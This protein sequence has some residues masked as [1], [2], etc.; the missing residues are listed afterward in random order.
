MPTNLRQ[1]FDWKRYPEAEQFL[2]D[3]IV[4]FL[5]LNSQTS[6]LAYSIREK[7]SSPFFH[8]LDHLVLPDSK[9]TLATL[10]E[11]GFS[12]DPLAETSPGR[13]VY[14]HPGAVFP[15]VILEEGADPKKPIL[16]AA[17]K[18]ESV[19]DFT[20]HHCIRNTIEGAPISRFRKVLIYEENNTRLWAVERRAYQGY[21]TE[22]PPF[23]YYSNYLKAQELWRIRPRFFADDVQGILKTE[24]LVE[25]MISLVGKGLAGH[26]IFEGERNYWLKRNRTAQI[27]KWRQD[28]LGLGWTNHDHHT[29]RCSRRHLHDLVRILEKLGF[30]CRE[31]FYAG[32]EAGWGAQILEHPVLD[33]SIFADLDLAPEETQEDFAHHPL[34]MRK[35]LGTVGLWVGLH[36]ESL[37]QAGLH[38][39]AARFDFEKLREDLAKVGIQTMKPFSYF[40]F[41]KQAFTQGEQWPLAEPDRAQRLLEEGSIDQ[42]QYKKFT[43]EGA[44]G[45]HLENLQRWEG[46][47][48]FNQRSVSAIIEATDPRK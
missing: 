29:F 26:L 13:T 27:Q 42:P 48:G 30:Q 1:Q 33:I 3:R 25:H 17:L 36:G 4:A 43:T 7:T 5:R 12:K 2:R 19:V 18:T 10:K 35:E 47:K 34:P 6:F 15:R 45:S 40:P 22:T 14:Y 24:E 23:E 37:L 39:L 28:S 21:L 16:E 41:L 20:A 8:W 31:R 44:L 38:H 9:E 32:Q 11:L 46:F